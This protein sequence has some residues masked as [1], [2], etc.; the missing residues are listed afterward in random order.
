[1]SGCGPKTHLFHLRRSLPLPGPA[2]KVVLEEARYLIGS[3]AGVTAALKGDWKSAKIFWEG[4]P[5]DC[6]RQNNMGLAL[7]LTGAPQS[8]VVEALA[9]AL[10]A[11]PRSEEIQ[12][13]Y[14]AELVADGGVPPRL[15]R[16]E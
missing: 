6:A 7:R 14:R 15:R 1:M 5:M 11:C 9:R 3:D 8:Q 2:Q 16:V 10:A 12:W 4:M 13:N